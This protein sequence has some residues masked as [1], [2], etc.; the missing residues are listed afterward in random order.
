MYVSS[1]EPS[2][3]HRFAPRLYLI[4]VSVILLLIVLAALSV[5]LLMQAWHAMRQSSD[6]LNT[7]GG[8]PS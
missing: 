5:L 8:P 1:L 2:V 3:V 7:S 6:T 4:M